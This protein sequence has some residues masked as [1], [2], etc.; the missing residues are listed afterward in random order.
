MKLTACGVIASAAITRSPSFSTLLI[1]NHN[2]HSSG[3]KFLNSVVDTFSKNRI[4][5]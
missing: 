5:F 1:I 4:D 2:N 3:S